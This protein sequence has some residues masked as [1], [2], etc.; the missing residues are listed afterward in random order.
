MAERESVRHT[1][2]APET[3]DRNDRMS[4]CLTQ[5]HENM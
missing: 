3:E 1:V 2:G 5:F 4:A